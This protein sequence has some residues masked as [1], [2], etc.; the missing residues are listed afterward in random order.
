[1]PAIVLS[2][3]L[4]V[5]WIAPPGSAIAPQDGFRVVVNTAN[6]A[7][8]L[9]ADEMSRIFLRRTT[10]WP[11][12]HAAVPVDQPVGSPARE[13]FS[14]AVHGMK[15]GA[16]KA[17]W[18]RQIFTGNGVPPVERASDA[19]VLELVRSDPNAVG[20]VGPETPLGPGVRVLQITGA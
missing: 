13:L 1:M 6:P 9:S 10:R 12:G 17:Y 16:V 14:Q 18:R 2:F 5:L 3:L 7:T 19:E 15:V 8:S 20:Y 4:A 11:S